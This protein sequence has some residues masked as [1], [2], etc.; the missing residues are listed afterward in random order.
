MSIEDP[1][2]EFSIPAKIRMAAR[3]NTS[4]DELVQQTNL[5]IDELWTMSGWFKLIN[6]NTGNWRVAI[7]HEGTSGGNWIH[8][9]WS[10][11]NV[12]GFHA[13]T[14]GTDPMTKP[15]IG[16]WFFAIMS[17]DGIGVDGLE[18]FVGYHD[19]H[20]EVEHGQLSASAATGQMSWAMDS[21]AAEWIDANIVDGAMWNRPLTLGEKIS[22]WKRG[23]RSVGSGLI[24]HYPFN[25]DGIDLVTRLEIDDY[26]GITFESGLVLP[27]GGSTINIIDDPDPNQLVVF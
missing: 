21:V 13:A 8:I 14:S 5:P 20:Y 9:G 4:T 27:Y 6:D 19:G 3:V 17:R 1:I 18:G 10:N 11:T 15:V 22:V 2:I 7:I 24:H 16:E 12:F 23:P 25:G 26:T